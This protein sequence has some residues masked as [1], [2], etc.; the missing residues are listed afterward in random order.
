M[1]DDSATIADLRAQLEVARGNALAAEEKELAAK[2]MPLPPKRKNM[3]PKLLPLPPKRK[4]M[5]PQATQA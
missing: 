3:P 5:P 1:S 4:N 2:L